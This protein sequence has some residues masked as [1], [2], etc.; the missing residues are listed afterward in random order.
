MPLLEMW[1]WACGSKVSSRHAG[2]ANAKGQ[3]KERPRTDKPTG[4]DRSGLR[5]VVGAG[6]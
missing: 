4:G 3:F 6:V 1:A 2:S 5:T